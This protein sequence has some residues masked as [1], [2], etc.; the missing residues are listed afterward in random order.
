MIYF[1]IDLE[2]THSAGLRGAE[3]LCPQ[4]NITFFFSQNSKN[5]AYGKLRKIFESGCK[6][7][8]CKLVRSGKNALD[9]YIAGKIGELYGSGY[10]GDVAIV[11]K[12]KD[13]RA[14]C[15]YWSQCANPSRNVVMRQNIEESIIALNENSQRRHH[16]Q[17][18][19]QSADLEETYQRF[20]EERR[21]YRALHQV[22][23]SAEY[24]DKLNL[25]MDFVSANGV[26]G[27]GIYLTALKIF[28]RTKGLELYRTLKTINDKAIS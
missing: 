27:R 20:L 14:V 13:F 1:M 17:K 9:F 11:S 28:G 8:I 2:N 25:M 6:I 7:D 4:D 16:I 10:Q 22:C 26:T 21:I 3:Y 18:E 12:D 5:V 24:A 23:G 19:L 15:D